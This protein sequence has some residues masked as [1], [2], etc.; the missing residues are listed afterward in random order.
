MSHLLKVLALSSLIALGGVLAIAAAPWIDIE[1]ELGLPWLY[2]A[3]G[4]VRAPDEVVVVAIDEASAQKLG[5]SEKPRDW[6]RSLHAELV[7]YLAQAGARVVAFD[8]TFDTSSHPAGQDAEFAA[9]LSAAGNVLVTESVREDKLPLDGPGGRP[10]ASVVIEKLVL[11]IPVIEAAVQGHAPFVVPKSSRVDEYWTFRGGAAD[12]PTLPVLAAQF[13]AGERHQSSDADAP[14]EPQRERIHNAL[15][16][17]HLS[18]ET[19]YL[20]LYGPPHTIRTV[21]YFRVI[22]AARAQATPG[23]PHALGPTEFRGKAVFVGFSASSPGGQDRLRDDYR[24]VFSRA[25]GLDVSGVELAATAFANLLEDRPLRPAGAAW[26]LAIVATWALML[27]VVCHALRPSHAVAAAGVLVAVYLW[28]VYDRFAGAAWWWPS[29]IPIGVQVPLAL[30][31]GIWFHEREASRQREAIKEAFGYFLPSAMVDQ[32]AHNIEAVSQANRLVFGSC[33]STD[34]SKYTTLAEAM[35]PRQLGE[36]LNEYF[37]ELFVPVERSGGVVMDVVGDA[38]VA[39]WTAP[40]SNAD[41]RRKAC[42]AALEIVAAVD[43]FNAA[44]ARRP[45]LPTRFG[46]HSGDI[47]IGNVGASHHYE[48]RAVGDIINT[49]SRLQGLNKVLGTRL[50][51]S[52]ATVEGLDGLLT[53]PMG[54]FL[55]AGKATAL[56][57][58]ELLGLQ[59]SASPAD[60]RLCERFT[61][62]LTSYRSREWRDAAEQLTQILS[63]VP[64]DGPS[65]FLLTRCTELLARPPDDSWNPTIEVD[66]K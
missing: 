65:R 17:L 21:P 58:V 57:V 25:D 50:L 52:V 63:E 12:A 8:L 64:D 5:V 19:S 56:Q 61:K 40:V 33:L 14:P 27:A 3:R 32:L 4:A 9:A 1:Q 48:Y 16:Y 44:P 62:A 31:A 42:E 15:T 54:S 6:P 37:A 13:Y 29:V 45:P 20:N 53:R 38:M 43:R 46:L 10:G 35:D 7:R 26:Q 34:V 55:L 23:D 18:G 22:E 59:I 24:T 36:L 49:A 28:G 47:L 51:A 66:A 11:P 39:V 41:I 60:A 30:F 2:A